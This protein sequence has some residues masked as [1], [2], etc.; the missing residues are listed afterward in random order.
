ME[1]TVRRLAQDEITAMSNILLAAYEEYFP[2]DPV[3]KDEREAWSNYRDDIADVAGRMETYYPP[4]TLDFQHSETAEVTTPTDWAGIRLLGVHPSARGLGIGRLLMTTA[5]EMAKEAGASQM[6]LHTTDD[7]EIARGMYERTGFVRDPAF[8]FYP[9]AG[10]D[11]V[12]VAYRL[13]L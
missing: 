9:V 6:A 7:M 2:A 4:G 3:S 13:A 10:S 8:D 12:V 5:I 11:F 1:P